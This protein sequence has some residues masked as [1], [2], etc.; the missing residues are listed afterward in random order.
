MP[1]C[2]RNDKMYSN[3]CTKSHNISSQFMIRE[4]QNSTIGMQNQDT[5]K[6]P[7][8]SILCTLW[9][10]N[11]LYITVTEYCTYATVWRKAGFKLCFKQKEKQF[12]YSLIVF[13]VALSCCLNQYNI[14]CGFRFII[15]Y[16]TFISYSV[17]LP[18][19]RS[20]IEL[21]FQWLTIACP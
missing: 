11:V 7:V 6:L 15:V 13:E 1:A 5:H 19:V 4:I 18:T 20:Y 21:V 16:N 2:C 10:S 14:S 12:L 8:F 9:Y 3:C 17:V